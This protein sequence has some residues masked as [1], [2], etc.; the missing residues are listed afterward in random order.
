MCTHARNAYKHLK[1]CQ[2]FL[3]GGTICTIAALSEWTTSNL[4]EGNAAASIGSAVS[5]PKAQA[6]SV[7]K[8]CVH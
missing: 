3:L 7:L 1:L 6:D 4:A 8:N 5:T 2:G